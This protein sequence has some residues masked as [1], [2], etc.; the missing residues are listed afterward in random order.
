VKPLVMLAALVAAGGTA[1]VTTID[2]PQTVFFQGNGFQ[3]RHTGPGIAAVARLLD[4]LGK[5]DPAVCEMVSDQVGN[6]W[7][8]ENEAGIGA[9]HDARVGARAVRDSLSGK[10]SDAAAIELLISSLQNDDPCVR[11]TAAKMLGNS[12]VTDG[13]LG[14][15]LSHQSPRVREA[16]ALAAGSEDRPA[17]RQLLETLLTAGETNSAAMAAWALGQ[18]ELPEAIPALGRATRNGESRTKL[19]AIWALGQVED[20]RAVEYLRPALRDADELTRVTAVEALGNIG[21]PAP[22]EE[23]EKLVR[24]DGSRKVRLAAIGA[25]GNLEQAGSVT[26]LAAVMEQADMELAIAAAEAI[27][28][29]DELHV[30]PPALLRAAG[31]TNAELRR[32]VANTL[33]NISDPAALSALLKLINDPEVEIRLAA[34]SGLEGIGSREAVP[35]LTKALADTD[36]EVRRAAAEALGEIEER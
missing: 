5:T 26:V 36:A 21:D 34:I 14:I 35:A 19:A 22:T 27:S 12:T 2:P 1:A 20:S 18:L 7:W 24:N 9:L 29:L 10:V 3:E 23:L 6:F 32:A 33:S 4:A 11:R 13:K 17:L 16:A 15:L 28:N 31:S 8:S 30:A 25:L